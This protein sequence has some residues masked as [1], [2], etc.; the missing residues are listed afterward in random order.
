MIPPIGLF[1]QIFELVEY[2]DR[3]SAFYHTA[4]IGHRNLRWDHC[5]QMDMVRLNIHLYNFNS[6]LLGKRSNTVT[7]FIANSSC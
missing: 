7:D 3:R 5:K 2:A 1:L 6:L 4:I